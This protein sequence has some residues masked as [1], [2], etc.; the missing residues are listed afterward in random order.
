MKQKH[1]MM[2]GGPGTIITRHKNGFTVM[3]VTLASIL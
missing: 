3:S 2:F 1:T